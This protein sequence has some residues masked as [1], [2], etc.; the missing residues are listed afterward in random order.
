MHISEPKRVVPDFERLPP[1]VEVF[2]RVDYWDRYKE[3]L[4]IVRDCVDGILE[5]WGVS[6]VP[7]LAT[8]LFNSAFCVGFD[9]GHQFLKVAIAILDV[10]D[11]INVSGYEVVSTPG[12]LGAF[13]WNFTEMYNIRF[14]D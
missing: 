11:L 1:F 8:Q 3:T 5:V 9:G 7:L 12:G 10:F 4:G 6:G 2:V 14:V 13:P